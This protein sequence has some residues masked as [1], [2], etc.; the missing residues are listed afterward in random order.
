MRNRS[1]FIATLANFSPNAPLSSLCCCMSGSGT[2]WKPARPFLSVCQG[3]DP[4]HG[5]CGA[6][7]FSTSI[8]SSMLH[9]AKLS[10]HQLLCDTGK[11]EQL[12]LQTSGQG[13]SSLFLNTSKDGNVIVVCFKNFTSKL[14]K[15]S[16]FFVSKKSRYE[17]H[18]GWQWFTFFSFTFGF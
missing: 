17:L 12:S 18:Y 5:P 9:A 3:G 6:I 13:S 4:L 16:C 11:R 14:T 7:Y 1:F 15:I 2:A 8:G 10:S